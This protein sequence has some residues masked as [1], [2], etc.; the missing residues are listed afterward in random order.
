MNSSPSARSL[1]SPSV[2]S[3]L[4][5]Q[6]ALSDLAQRLVE[7]ARRAGADQADAVAVRGVSHGVEVR[8]GRMQESE[9][10]EGDDVGLRVIVGRRQAVVSTNDISGDAV[11]KLAERAVAMARVA[12][13]DKYVGL[14]D[15]E[16]LA[17]DFPE[18]DLLDPNTPSTAE[19]ERRARA[20]EAAALAVPGINKSGGASAS[21]GIGGMVLVTSTGFQGSF[22]RSSHSISMTAIAG[23]GTGMERDY[24]YTTAP[25]ASDLMSPEEVGRVAG[26]R[27]AARVGPRKVET[28][29]VPVVFDPRVAGSLVGHL[30]GAA[31]GASI[32]RK[33]SFLKDRLGQKLFKDG[34]RIVDDPLRKRGLRSQ[35]FDAE[36]VAVKP[37]SIVDDGVLTS[38]LLDCA[39]ARELG[40]TTTGHAHR[41]V[42]SSPSPG[43][44]NLHLEAGPLSPAELIADIKQGFYVTD[45]IGSGV[46]GV[47]GDYSRGAAGFWIE[48]GQRTY[49][50]SEV[51]IA[52]HLIDMY[53][54]LTPASDLTFRYG[55]N[56]P[57]LRIE[58]LTI[59][60]R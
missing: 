56:A 25:H 23:E 3:A 43:P 41:G 18:L 40:L 49:A 11:T 21:S 53:K 19:L 14:A 15:P 6:S 51:T 24:E 42:S 20:A 10:S 47:T 12:P 37:L 30:V 45:L 52:G 59:A 29:K 31:N 38:W 32:A 2:D 13:D 33:T 48:N 9:R 46:N 50:V 54:T 36:G 1:S 17:H 28:C 16:L 57:T 39:T 26:E 7:A 4:F 5:D 60:G 22:L 35:A 44:Y 55:V 34:I 58:G 8:D 27:T